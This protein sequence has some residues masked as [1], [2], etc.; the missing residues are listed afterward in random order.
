MQNNNIRVSDVSFLSSDGK[1]TVRGKIY[2]PESPAIGVVML[3]HGMI[4]HIGR[5]ESFAKVM[6][7]NGFIFAAHNHLGHGETAPA[8]SELGYIAQ[9][10][11]DTLMVEDVLKMNRLLAERFPE[12]PI[13]LFGH[14]MGSFISR[15]Y[16][17]KYPDTVSGIVIHGTGGPNPLVGLGRFLAGAVS[18]VKGSHCRSKLIGTLAF[19]SYNKR[20]DESEG[21]WAWLT[22]DPEQVADRNTD[23]FASFAFTASGY[24]DLFTLVRDSNSRGWFKSYPLDMPTLIVSGEDDPVG[25][26]GKGPRKVYDRLAKEGVTPLEIKMYPDARHELFNERCREEFYSD[27][28]LWLKSTALGAKSKK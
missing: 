5:Y 10:R 22:S 16:G 12:L 8:P 17:V 25:D 11:G 9:K 18:A 6:C 21:F 14:S 23:P 2:E 15:I 19:G 1:C 24:R 20:F 27:L 4:D 28:V 7:E 3:A 13:I 26:F